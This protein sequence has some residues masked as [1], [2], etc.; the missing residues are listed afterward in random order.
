MPAAA[1][2]FAAAA[3]VACSTAPIGLSSQ[4]DPPSRASYV[5]GKP[6]AS[7]AELCRIQI[8]HFTDMRP[9]SQT[10]G[11]MGVR[12]VRA[13]TG[14]WVRSGIE[15]LARDSRIRFVS[16]PS[17]ADLSI[18]VELLK[19]YVMTITVDKS[20]NVAVRIRYFRKGTPQ[21]DA[22]YRGTDTDVN[23]ANGDDE[24]QEALNRALANMLE[25]VDRDLLARCKG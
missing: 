14:A 4:F 3:L 23:W 20:S 7:Q 15:S 13:D 18:D 5:S 10:M 21:G 11:A 24:T 12:T 25:D 19:A 6:P 16:A 17:E 1:L 9:D 2:A 22:L 8:A